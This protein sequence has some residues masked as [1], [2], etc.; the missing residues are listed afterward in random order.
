MRILTRY[1][2]KEVFS[3]AAIG[4]AVFTFV[5]FTRDLGRI[6]DL[7][8]RNSAPLPSVAEIFFFTVPVALTYTIPVGV[9][10]GVLLGLSRL[11]ADS[12]ITAM[13][14]SGIGV[15]AFVR[16][17]SIFVLGAWMLA[18]VNDVV[19]APRSQAAL[20][21]L[22]DKLKSSQASFEVQPN[23]FYEGFPKL[24]LYVQDVHSR[25]EAAEW[26][27]VFLANFTDPNNPSITL[28]QN[29]ILVGEGP[30]T[31]HLHLT[32]GA[33]HEAVPGQADRYQ[34]STFAESDIPIDLPASDTQSQPVSVGQLTTTEL[35]RAQTSSGEVN[36]KRWELIELHRRF[37]LATACIVLALVGIPLG[38]SFKKGGKSAGFVLTIVL[39]FAYYSASLLGI[40]LAREVK[41]T[42]GEGVWIANAIFFITGVILLW[43]VE[44]RP[45]DTS[46]IRNFWVSLQSTWR[47]RREALSLN[48]QGEANALQ[49]LAGRRVSLGGF[50]MLLD[51]YILRDF[52][53]YF[54]MILGSFLMLL[55]VFTLFELIGDI[56]RNQISPIIVAE[57]LLN[58][59][60]YFI[61]NVT[62]LSMLLAVLVTFGL[63]TR[64]NEITAIKATGISIYR[65][66][67]PVLVASAIL[68]CGLFAFD[69]LYLPVTN[70]R[71]DELRNIIKGKPPQ[72]YQIPD[73]KWIKGQQNTIYFYKF[74]EPDRNEFG[75]LTIFKY[76]PGSFGLSQRIYANRAHWSPSLQKW[77]CEQGWERHFRGAAIQDYRQYDAS[78]FATLNEPP[79]YF[80]KE[81]KQFTEMNYEELKR[82]I[83][84]LQERGFDVVRLR[85]QLEKK[86]AYPLIT[87]VMAV[88]AVPF[89]L[90][91]GRRGAVAGI[92]IAVTIA[93]VYWTI[94]GLSES[95]GNV[96]QLPPGLAA[97]APDMFFGLIGGYLI[98]RV[99]T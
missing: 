38:L 59:S 46:F 14:A 97:W 27:G 82:Y 74:F 19:V 45:L 52:I 66:I 78:T 86:F 70:K 76:D 65:I 44:R 2:L 40:S 36:L 17:V 37:A 96:S 20:E 6:L 32:N 64:S 69:Q 47:R 18:L 41:V 24:V 71:Q 60:P 80:K 61:Y 8:A 34:I 68:A 62:P 83:H 1:I 55:L 84:D 98:L 42:P 12:E 75:D 28:A 35:W 91:A 88:L 7:V 23:V 29:G 63:M 3:H 9:L 67:V 77:V 56:L 93:V 5:L 51:D 31:L 94:S 21:R 92:A 26:K 85:V 13:R 79:P 25:P 57:Y 73:R 39:V 30:Q 87:L 49:R 4:V 99:P 33:T 58:V 48:G 11:A 81:V 15:W 53:L 10:V 43:R 54:S 72:T 89:A 50:P 90:S 95:M 22:Q 16:I